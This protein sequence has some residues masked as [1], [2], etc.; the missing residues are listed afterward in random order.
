[1]SLLRRTVAKAF[2]APAGM[3]HSAVEPGAP[4][5]H[6]EALGR[7]F[8][9][10]GRAFEA[11]GCQP[12]RGGRAGVEFRVETPGGTVF[13]RNGLHGMVS[14]RRL[15]DEE[16]GAV[17]ELLGVQR[18]RDEYIPIR[19]AVTDEPGRVNTRAAGFSYTS[20]SELVEEYMEGN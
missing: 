18:L 17:V 10:L 15:V 16:G 19:K 12:A 13:F 6:S 8:G 20:V 9:S 3:S 5:E 2:S 7:F 11:R 1:M 14:V 4:R